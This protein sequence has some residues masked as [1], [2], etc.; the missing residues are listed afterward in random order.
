MGPHK[1]RSTWYVWEVC[2]ALSELNAPLTDSKES[3]GTSEA[4]L[5]SATDGPSTS[6]PLC[7]LQSEALNVIRTTQSH[8]P[9]RSR[10]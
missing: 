4:R 3:S 2:I 7:P 6:P 8:K 5:A 9:H 1:Y 10:K